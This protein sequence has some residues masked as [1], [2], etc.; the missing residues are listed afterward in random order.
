MPVFRPAMMLLPI[1]VLAACSAEPEQPAPE[2]PDFNLTEEAPA[3]E[4]VPTFEPLPEP[5][6]SP[7][8]TF[9]SAP[10]PPIEEDEQMIDDA[11]ATGMTSR[12]E[13]EDRSAADENAPENLLAPMGE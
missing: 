10:P 13:R 8:P 2:G 6:P 3:P 1:A 11:Q 4:P 9:E 5:S 12:I 7:V